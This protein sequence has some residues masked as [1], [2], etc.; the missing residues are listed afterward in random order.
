MNMKKIYLLTLAL[1][2]A[3]QA[4][5]QTTLPKPVAKVATN[6]TTSGFNANWQ[7]VKGSEAYCVYVY[8]H[9]DAKAG[10]PTTIAD[11]D[12]SGVTQGSVVSP[13][14]SDDIYVD[15][16]D[17]GYATT[18]GWSA[19]GYP[20]FARGMVGGVI[21]SPYLDLRGNNGRYQIVVTSYCNNGDSIFVT[22]HG[23]KGETLHKMVTHVANGA[24]GYSTDTLTCDDGSKDLFFTVVNNTATQETPDFIDRVQVLQ[25]LEGTDGFYAMV[26]A[27][28]SVMAQD[29]QTG[30]QVTTKRFATPTR[31]TKSKVLYYD[32]YA[33]KNDSTQPRAGIPYTPVYSP[34]SDMVK[35][36]LANK[37]S[38]VLSTEAPQ[39]QKD[40]VN[41]GDYQG[42]LDG[43]ST[44]KL[45]EGSFFSVAPT[46]FYLK[47]TGS[48]IIYTKADLAQVAGKEITALKFVFNN[49]GLYQ[50]YPR[51]VNVKMKEIGKDAFEYDND[52]KDYLFFEENDAKAV[53][54]NYQ[55]DEDFSAYYG[56]NGEMVLTLDKPFAYTGTGN[57]L[58]SISFDGTEA[59]ESAFDMTFY[60]NPEAKNKA[61]TFT[62]DD[63]SFADYQET[64]DWPKAGLNT[65]TRL[66]QPVT[67]LVYQTPATP[68]AIS[69]AATVAPA[70]SDAQ[71]P[72]YNL[73]G[74]RVSSGYKG[75]VIKGHKK[76]IVR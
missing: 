69:N 21:Y 17:Y 68:T 5:A 8:E 33:V 26:A 30:A 42:A 1:P 40:S 10:A 9:K 29:E 66:E 65:G 71:A 43:A 36:D 15:L 18:Y 2:L 67:Q 20:S 58:V 49:Q 54:S 47:H 76:M 60:Y 52:R 63:V 24:T 53:L 31:Y 75:F 72:A 64:D 14:M 25:D 74:Q 61:M 28:E 51:T 48:Q 13:E 41:V 38:E 37:T 11:E 50:A 32:L 55:Y 4:T 23:S 12:F 3:L 19:Y 34:Y 70:R 59:C 44:A 56:T 7:A 6:I 35:V 45:Y 62:H 16:S 73:A 46:T 39:P 27:D 22:T 57:L